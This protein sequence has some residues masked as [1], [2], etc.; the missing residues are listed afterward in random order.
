[1]PE[2]VDTPAPQSMTI[3]LQLSDRRNA[4]IPWRSSDRRCS[5]GWDGA[6]KSK[7][8]GC[9]PSV[10]AYMVFWPCVRG[11]LVVRHARTR[12]GRQV[13]ADYVCYPK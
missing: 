2:L 3:D 8:S 5:F 1:M 9:S 11:A 10:L 7:R 13:F 4:A 12:R 6:L